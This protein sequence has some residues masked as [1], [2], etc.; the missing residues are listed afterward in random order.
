M[1]K[2][3]LL[4][5]ALCA[6]VVYGEFTT[7]KV[8]VNYCDE[9]KDVV[10]IILNLA[11]NGT[12]WNTTKSDLL[13]MCDGIF[14]NSTL[15]RD[16]CLLVVDVGYDV[17]PL[18]IKG[19]NLLAWEI[20]ATVCS[21]V[22]KLCVMDCCDTPYTPQEIR[23]NYA[24]T[25]DL[26]SIRVSWVTLNVSTEP[27][28]RYIAGN[29]TKVVPAEW[30]TYTA[31]GWRGTI[32][33]AVMGNL[34]RDSSVC[35][36]VGSGGQGMSSWITFRTLPLDIGTAK[37]PLR[38]AQIADMGYGPNSDYTV[39][40]L[41]ELATSGA[42]DLI[43][44][45]GDVSYADGDETHW[46]VYFTKVQPIVSVVPYMLSPGNHELWWNFTAYRSRIAKTMPVSPT[47]LPGAMYYRFVVGPVTLLSLDS[48]SVIDTPYIDDTQIEWAK[49]EL[50]Q[51]NRNVTP[52]VW[53][54]H[55]R[56]LY[57]AVNPPSCTNEAAYLR[58]RVEA[59][60][61]AHGVDVA[62]AGHLHYYERTWPVKDGV[63]S[64]SYVK[65]TAPV[66]ITNGAA[67]N[68]EG[69]SRWTTSP[70]VPGGSSLIGYALMNVTVDTLQF[71][72]FESLTNKYID[73][74]TIKK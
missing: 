62:F 31:G 3:I 59:A 30:W 21:D 18:L 24:N 17:I 8:S 23:I 40:R 57:C 44:H 46:D 53:V 11:T 52:W 9:C 10:Q 15:E 7:R 6:A 54:M 73:G 50:S 20:P 13:L 29:V 71:A 28:V 37:R 2:H 51:V 19:M 35:Y 60:Y 65:P 12:E 63:P 58:S 42:L 34:P 69:Q 22:V 33:S 39:K 70:I 49:A 25:D 67:G 74:M 61:V 5:S 47:A 48:E 38:V 64:T 68:R 41:T 1:L 4:V 27:T 16:I 66:Y 72:F 56:P 14:A 36:Q 45:P 26:S 43:I 32:Y 55:H